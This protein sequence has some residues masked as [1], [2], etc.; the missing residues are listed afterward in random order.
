MRDPLQHLDPLALQ[1]CHFGR[2]VG[3]QAHLADAELA[4]D[5]RG[6]SIVALVVG[7]AEP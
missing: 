7:E 5:R 2:I 4:Q 1:R 6:M 3:E